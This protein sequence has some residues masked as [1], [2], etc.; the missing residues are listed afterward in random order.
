MTD[1]TY[2][3]ALP[4]FDQGKTRN[5][6]QKY[7]TTDPFAGPLFSQKVT[8]QSPVTWDITITCVG[9]QARIM[10]I[11]LSLVD[12]GQEFKKMILTETGHVEHVVS[13]AVMPLSPTQVGTNV[14]KYS[15][16]IYAPKL[17]NPDED[18]DNPELIISWLSEA[19]LIDTTMN[20]TWPE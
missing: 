11:W 3:A 15:G 13:F 17:I 2:P 16:T 5:E 6:A 10:K 9:V 1:I 19:H 7:R 4:D 14:W 20:E 12:V 8:D 18:I